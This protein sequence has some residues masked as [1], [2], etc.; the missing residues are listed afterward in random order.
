MQKHAKL[1]SLEIVAVARRSVITPKCGERRDIVSR[2]MESRVEWE[3]EE[4]EE[5]RKREGIRLG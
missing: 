4:E 5:E 3:K 2:K 1:F